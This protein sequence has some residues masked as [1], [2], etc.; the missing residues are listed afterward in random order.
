MKRVWKARERVSI[1]AR[2]TQQTFGLEQ[3]FSF[4]R[5]MCYTFLKSVFL[6]SPTGKKNI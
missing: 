5:Y 4:S 6:F 1:K 3:G 2:A